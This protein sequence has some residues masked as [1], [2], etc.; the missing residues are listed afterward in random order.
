[1]TK[2]E[3]DRKSVKRF[4]RSNGLDTAL[5]KNIP[6]PFFTCED[7]GERNL[8]KEGPIAIMP[9]NC[10]RPDTMERWY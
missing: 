10:R 3:T 9:D 1:M 5:Y 4:E 8:E 7:D 2:L 6:F